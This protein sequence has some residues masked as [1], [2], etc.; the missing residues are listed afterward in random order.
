MQLRPAF[1]V[2]VCPRSHASCTGPTP[3]RAKG[4]NASLQRLEN[5]LA[6][7]SQGHWGLRL[8]KP[9][10]SALGSFSRVTACCAQSGCHPASHLP[11]STQWSFYTACPGR[12]PGPLQVNDS[13]PLFTASV[14]S[15]RRRPPSPSGRAEIRHYSQL[16]VPA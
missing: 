14:R 7:G 2:R 9:S 8:E 11:T 3:S 12:A 10:A 1:P 5:G 15:L 4:N 6:G 13:K 16:P